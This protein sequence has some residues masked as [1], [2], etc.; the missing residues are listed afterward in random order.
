M[1][2]LGDKMTKK[3][4]RNLKRIIISTILF[5][6]VKIT[7]IIISNCFNNYPNGIASL[8][9]F[10]FGWLLPFILYFIIYIYIG[11]DV[12]KKA[13]KN[14]INGQLFDENFLMAVATVGAFVLQEYREAS[15]VMI[16]YQIGELFQSIA[17]GKSRKNIYRANGHSLRN[18]CGR[19]G[20]IHNPRCKH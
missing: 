5:L 4:K 15:A 20:R 18:Y 13:F 9:P 8:I 10:D 17:V 6:I 7:D 16:F 2:E 12:L 3:Q 14:I 1:L 11:H 19:V